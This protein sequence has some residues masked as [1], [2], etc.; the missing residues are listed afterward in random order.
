MPRLGCCQPATAISRRHEPPHPAHLHIC[1]PPPIRPDCLIA[2]HSCTT[3]SLLC[4]CWELPWDALL[5]TRV[6]GARRDRL[7]GGRQSM[8]G[9]TS[10]S[11]EPKSCG[12]GQA[13]GSAG[14]R[15]GVA[16]RDQICSLQARRRRR[17]GAGVGPA[18]WR[19][20]PVQPW[21]A[22]AA[23]LIGWAAPAVAELTVRL[24]VLCWAGQ[25]CRLPGPACSP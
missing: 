13:L 22:A 25:Q 21:P 20:A 18:G 9:C 10:C 14:R 17:R 6:S 12:S 23:A 11:G 8:R 4:C 1:P 5:C 2:C 7:G 24:T 16:R 15:Q 3:P 19:T